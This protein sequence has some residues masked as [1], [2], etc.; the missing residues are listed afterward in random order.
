MKNSTARF[1]LIDKLDRLFIKEVAKLEAKFYAQVQSF[2]DRHINTDGRRVEKSARNYANLNGLDNVAKDFVNKEA[3]KISN[4]VAQGFVKLIN[5]NENYFGGI[6]Y[7]SKTLKSK[8][9]DELLA[10]YGANVKKGRLIILKSGWLQ[11]L[12][13]VTDPF[14]RMQ[15][16]GLNA[17][18][19][20]IPLERLRKE[21][22]N[23]AFDSGARTIK[24]HFKTNANDAYAQFDRAAQVTYADEL[25][26]EAFIYEGG[27]IDETRPFCEK[28]NGLVF[29]REE[30][31]LWA[32]LQW[33]GKNKD[34]VPMRDL[35]GH[36]CRHHPSF[37][38][39]ELA[40]VLRPDLNEKLK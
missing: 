13:N 27:L 9:Q 26:L 12:A 3:S 29:T 25:N 14:V 38:P 31:E 32:N 18:A 17:V 40:I 5:E 4:S 39:N 35:G 23:A 11:K 28:R 22:K 15:E 37:I 8:V 34:Y 1:K 36:N 6:R 30:A 19:Q 10:R 16:I 21:I 20:G 7:I 2:Y 33:A 24:H